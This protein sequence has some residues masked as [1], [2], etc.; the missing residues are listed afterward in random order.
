MAALRSHN[1]FCNW[2]HCDAKFALRTVGSCK[3]LENPSEGRPTCETWAFV[4]LPRTR[5]IYVCASECR[6]ATVGLDNTEENRQAWRELLYSAPGLGQVVISTL[7]HC[8][9]LCAV[10][11]FSSMLLSVHWRFHAAR[12][13]FSRYSSPVTTIPMFFFFLR[14][15]VHQWDY[16]V[17]RD[18][19]P[20]IS[21]RRTFRRHLEAARNSPWH[22]GGHRLATN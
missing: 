6:L 21:C 14:F 1:C 17:R 13:L 7:L 8:C 4:A 11:R 3:L 16:H 10:L 5:G 2:S 22:Q 15:A 19:V 12:R 18:V 9:S 20:V